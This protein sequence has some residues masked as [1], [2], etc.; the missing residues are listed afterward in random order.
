MS[1]VTV[2]DRHTEYLTVEN[3]PVEV[4]DLEQ[5]DPSK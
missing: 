5:R 3:A 4:P 2:P 1:T